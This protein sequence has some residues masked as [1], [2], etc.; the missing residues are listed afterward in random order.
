MLQSNY[1]A[2]IRNLR[3]QSISF[4]LNFDISSIS[5][6][7]ASGIASI[8]I[9]PRSEHQII[10]SIR[11]CK[12]LE[13][14]YLIIGALSNTIFRSGVIHT[15]LIQTTNVIDMNIDQNCDK[16]SSKVYFSTGAFLASAES[17]LN[18]S[19]LT[20]FTSLVGIPAT[21][22]GA[23][24]MNAGSYGVQIQDIVLTVRFVDTSKQE[25]H[26]QEVS[27]HEYFQFSYRSSIFKM[28]E[29][30][31]VLGATFKTQSLSQKH[32]ERA[33]YVSIHRKSLQE[34]KL[35][36]LGSNFAT[37]NIYLE[38]IRH[39]KLAIIGSY[40]FRALIKI[41]RLTKATNFLTHISYIQ[42]HSFLLLIGLYKYRRY[43]S[44]KSA[45]CIINPDNS[46]SDKIISLLKLYDSRVGCKIENI[47]YDKIL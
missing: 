26:A 29:N 47:I 21:V 7:K 35:P 25:L 22:G 37:K 43:F 46:S 41:S 19:K 31:V 27:D 34:N 4:I 18:K 17:K 42:C 6:I 5:W 20:T 3:E 1:K 12:M 11:L 23:I 30:L 2:L 10:E 40:V 44:R 39:R 16:D 13:M 9:K 15:V 8:L 38:P 45:N 32:K 24:V 28:N 14:E 33:K 36:N